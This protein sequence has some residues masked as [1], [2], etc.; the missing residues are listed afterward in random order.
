[1]SAIICADQQQRR[2]R[3]QVGDT[4]AR[5]CVCVCFARPGV[6]MGQRYLEGRREGEH[7]IKSWD[8]TYASSSDSLES[9]TPPL[10][11]HF[12]YLSMRSTRNDVFLA[13]RMNLSSSSF[14]QL[15]LFSGSLFK[16][17]ATKFLNCWENPA[18]SS[19]GGG[20]FGMRNSTRIGWRSELG[21]SPFANSIAVTPSDQMSA[22]ASYCDCLI[23][24]GAIQ[25]GVP[26]KVVRLVMV[27]VS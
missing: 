9:S 7:I 12:L 16:Q 18:P 24:S 3:R 26:T 13:F 20:F 6:Q 8:G 22:D 2:P 19:V 4:V 10:S 27:S 1:M 11:T 23:T 25:N 5:V 21:G 17:A 14:L 15:G